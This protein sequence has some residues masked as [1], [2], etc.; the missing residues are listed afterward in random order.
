M[1]GELFRTESYLR[2]APARVA[3]H[4]PEG[5][6]ILDSS[7]FYPTGGGQPGDS[8]YVAW[9]G[10]EL[11]IATTVKG[12]GDQIVLVPAA[13]MAL[14]EVGVKLVQHLGWE[15]RHRHM[16]VHT[17]L[18]LLSVVLPLPV[19]GGQIGAGSGRLDFAMPQPP[20]DR[21][22]L[23]EALKRHGYVINTDGV[24]DENLERIVKDFQ[25]LERLTADGIVGASTR[26][27]LGI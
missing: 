12:E 11:E 6:V 8:G 19:T 16:R 2:D 5:G 18:H 14:P 26:A 1:T 17:A 24:F 27:A 22:A 4:T 15:R 7:L 21:E 3:A 20:E 9:D 23:E 25:Q 10:K 13:P